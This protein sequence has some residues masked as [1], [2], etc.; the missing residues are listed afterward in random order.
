MLEAASLQHIG[1]SFRASTYSFL[2]AGDAKVVVGQLA[3]PASLA[4]LEDQVG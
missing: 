4:N 3:A 2:Q 1:P